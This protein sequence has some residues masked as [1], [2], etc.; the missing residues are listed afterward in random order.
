MTESTAETAMAK[1]RQL[2]D[3]RVEAVQPLAEAYAKLTAARA[4]V[5]AAEQAAATA[6]RNAEKAGW[7]DNELKAVGFDAP[8]RRAPGRPPGPKRTATGNQTPAPTADN[9]ENTPQA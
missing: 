2:L 1:A 7:T 9:G 4:A 8:T 3:Q 6:Y 5:T